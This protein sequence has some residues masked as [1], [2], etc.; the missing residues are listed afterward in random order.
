MSSNSF[1]IEAFSDDDRA[2]SGSR[3]ADV[4][5]AL[6][7]NPYQQPWGAPDNA[8]LPI[9]G[10][11]LGRVLSGILPF[12][13]PYAFRKA[14]ERIVDSSADLRWGPDRKGYRRLL[15]PNGICLTG[16]WKIT[17]PT[18]YTGYFRQG[19]EALM[20]GRY[21]TCCTEPRR[22]HMRSLS[23]VGKLF[24]TTDPEHADPLRTAS[25]ITQQD[26][27]GDDTDYI[28]DAE[29]RNAPNT[30]VSR[31]GLGAAVL[32]LTGAVFSLVDKKPSIRQ[33][34]PIAELGKPKEEPTRAPTF[35]R[36]RVAP[37]QPKIAGESLDFRDEVMAQI[38]DRGDPAPK[39][40]LKFLID[41][42]DQGKTRGLPIRERRTFTNWRTIGS[43]AFDAAV[44]SYNGDF[45]IHFPHPTWRGD[46]N[47][48]QTATRVNRRKVG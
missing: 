35:M 45:V 9:Y 36:L 6:F 29:L 26:I 33:L 1:G 2:Y 28:N 18:D 41:V 40:T 20:V 24:P 17:E 44:A 47:D 46:Q 16:T 38:Y 39:R 4:R 43:I 7:A 19:S 14:T 22:G 10:V 34:Y 15:H 31:R 25:F 13:R 5:A 32:I 21:S 42:T 23:L 11:S 8:P 30:T 3:F 37:Q 12:G 48:P 27:G